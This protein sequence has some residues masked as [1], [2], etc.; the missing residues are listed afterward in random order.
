MRFDWTPVVKDG[1]KHVY[2]QY[3]IKVK[4]GKRDELSDYLIE[5]GIGNGI[6]YPI[7]LYN[8][9][10]YTN[11]G[12]NQSLP[13]TDEIVKDVLS[14]PIHAKLTKFDL[15]LIIKTIKDFAKK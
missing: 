4:D 7:P 2:H 6:Y 14:L 8:Q 5:N 3:T 15:D 9:V 13:V 11:M 12:Y 1:Y 10:L